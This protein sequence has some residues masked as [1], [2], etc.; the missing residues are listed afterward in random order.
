MHEDLDIIDTSKGKVTMGMVAQNNTLWEL[1]NVDQTL[2]YIGDI[3]GVP[4]IELE[5]QK[6]FIKE[7]LDLKPYS[8]TKAQNLS[9][10]NKRKLVC[11]M[12]LIGNP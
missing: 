6:E 7:T 8:K 11:A 5:F 9:G 2:Q 3:K 12:S 10:G 4:Q 1:L